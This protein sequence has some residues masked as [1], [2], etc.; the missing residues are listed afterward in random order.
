MVFKRCKKPGCPTSPRCDH[1]WQI[2]FMHK[3][4]YERGPASKYAK[5][6]PAARLPENKTQAQELEKLIFAWV[7]RGRP[8]HETTPSGPASGP[9]GTIDAALTVYEKAHIS[10]LSDKGVASIIKRMRDKVGKQSLVDILDRATVREFLDD[11]AEESSTVNSNRHY[12]RWQHFE[13]WCRGEYALAGPS[14]FY[15]RTLNRQGIRKHDEGDGRDRRLDPVEDAALDAAMAR[16][17]DGGMMRARY[18]A[19]L[20]CGL[21]RGEM[22]QL[23]NN[24]LRWQDGKPVLKVRWL[25]AKSKQSRDVYVRSARLTAF[26]QTR[27]FIKGHVFGQ[28]DGTRVEGFRVEWQSLMQI[29]GL[30]DR[31]RQ[32]TKGGF[33]MWVT[34]REPEAGA[35]HWHDLRHECGS[36]LAE[37]GV[38]QMEIMRYMGHTSLA[39][40]QR[41]MNARPTGIAANVER[42]MVAMGL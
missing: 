7:A 1:E 14:P 5:L 17:D 24:D 27:R 15:H 16:H 8:A 36:R 32:P 19:A 38:P 23:T 30:I 35:L 11:I 18:H 28:L 6:W 29:A 37:Q 40:T 39:T 33:E 9:A 25:T 3:G 10:R 12:S 2:A 13:G 26:L 21:R 4:Q 42:A 41:Y 31:E 34:T 22:L 20:D